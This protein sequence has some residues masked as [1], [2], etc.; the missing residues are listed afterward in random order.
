M[1]E[2]IKLP[3]ALS[4]SFLLIFLQMAGAFYSKSLA[5]FSHAGLI[6]ITAFS[7][8]PHLANSN[9]VDEGFK[10]AQFI[11]VFL[12]ISAFLFLVLII[13]CKAFA[14]MS[15]PKDV[16]MLLAVITTSI[17]FAGLIVC[18]FLSKKFLLQASLSLGIIM[19]FSIPA[20]KNIVFLDS[21]LSIFFAICILVQSVLLIKKT[22]K[23]LYH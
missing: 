13:I 9:N 7:F 15:A 17:V 12:N 22:I 8:L 3:A 14:R 1:K 21:Y 5:M 20:F 4:I 2:S 23:I 16:N 11:S 10:K 19:G 6:I 18:S